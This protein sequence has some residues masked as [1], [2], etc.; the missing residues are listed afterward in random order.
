M[1]LGLDLP[2]F[3][4]PF[5]NAMLVGIASATTSRTMAFFIV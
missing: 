3:G 5:A 1:T 4:V 2:W